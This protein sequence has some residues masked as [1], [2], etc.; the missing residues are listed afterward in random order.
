MVDH[1]L[2]AGC[3]NA[4]TLLEDKMLQF[5]H[6]LKYF[7]FTVLL[8]VCNYLATVAHAQPTIK[9]DGSSTVYPITKIVADQFQIAK[10]NTVA[11]I[12]DISGSGGGFKKFCRGEIDIVNASRPILRDEIQ[13]CRNSGI[14]YIEIPIAYDALTVAINP[15]NN[16]STQM[17]AI[18]LKKMWEPAAQGKITQWNQ[19][20]PAWPNEPFILYGADEDS[21][22]FDYFTEAIVGQAKS[23]RKDFTQSENDN[24]LV[25]GVASNK[26]AI[27]FFGVG[28]YIENQNRVTA[29]A[30]NNGKGAIL[31]FADTVEDGSYQPLSRPVFIYVNIKSADKPEVKE[32]VDFYLKNALLLVKEV[33]FFPL[34][35][36]A[37]KTMLE[38]FNSKRVGTIFNGKSAIGLTIDELIRREGRLQYE[39]Y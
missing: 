36:R 27:G 8:F 25:D 6:Y 28:Y 18:E 34:P 20:N 14:Q 32:F 24:Y 21:G 12:V 11:T 1:T 2:A 13:Q 38:H 22:T 9:I 29:V 3:S 17:T 10:N 31:P 23:I 7:S 5:P 30:I 33:K 16:W 37:Y 39:N 35:P 4:I 15:A 26:N 19:I